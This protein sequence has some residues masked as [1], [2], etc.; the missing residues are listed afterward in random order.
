MILKEFFSQIEIFYKPGMNLDPS[1]AMLPAN[2]AMALLKE[3]QYGAAESDCTLALSIDDTYVKAYQRRASARTGLGKYQLAIQDYDKVLEY[4]PGNK[5]AANEKTKL[6]EKIKAV[7]EVN[8][9]CNRDKT[10][11]NKFE[12]KMKGAFKQQH[13]KPSESKPVMKKK[14]DD[15]LVLPVDKPVHL[16]STKPL[17]RIQIQEVAS[18]SS[19]TPDTLIKTNKD[20]V[21]KSSGLTKKIEKEIVSDLSKIEIVNSIPPVPKTST[22]F[23]TDWKSLKTIVNR[24]KYLQQ[25]K[26][27]DYINVFKTSLEGNTFSD[28][29]AVLHHMVQRG[30]TPEVVVEQMN[31]LCRLPR[32]SAIAMFSTKSD[33]DKLRYVVSELDIAGE[34]EREKWNKTFSLK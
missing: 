24:T 33:L 23:L 18:L 2:R 21:S 3:Y 22:K 5:A 30:V 20:I 4:E 26:S 28:I 17:K 6:A 15:S 25:F 29:C 34:D 8:E 11:F 7:S 9:G 1:N 32:I 19:S 12:D 31:G 10:N 13:L 16:R 14:K 27:S